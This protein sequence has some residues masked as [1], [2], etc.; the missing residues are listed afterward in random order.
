MM[1]MQSRRIPTW[2]TVDLTIIAVSMIMI[3]AGV[4]IGFEGPSLP[5]MLTNASSPL[6]TADRAKFPAAHPPVADRNGALDG[7]M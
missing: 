6:T 2:L 1:D 3:A 4:W 7:H 5:Q